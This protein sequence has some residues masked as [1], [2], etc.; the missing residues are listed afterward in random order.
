MYNSDFN[1]NLFGPTL[2][3]DNT[4]EDQFLKEKEYALS[5]IS[6]DD[7]IPIQKSSSNNLNLIEANSKNVKD[8]NNKLSLSPDIYYEKRKSK[9]NSLNSYGSNIIIISASPDDDTK[10]C[11]IVR[12]VNKLI[13]EQNILRVRN[14]SK[15]RRIVK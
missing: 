15:R 3:L 9:R 12:E 7:S 13:R 4:F 11:P 5:P 6:L 2:I 10:E 1:K 8:K 14:P